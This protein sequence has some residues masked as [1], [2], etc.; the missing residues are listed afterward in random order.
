MFSDDGL[1]T[2]ESMIL[3]ASIQSDEW[4][5]H[6]RTITRQTAEREYSR[7]AFAERWRWLIKSVEQGRQL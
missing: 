4:L 6:H 3:N 5:Q 7:E 2:I 1:N